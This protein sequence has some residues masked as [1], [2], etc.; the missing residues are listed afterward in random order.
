MPAGST[1]AAQESQLAQIAATLPPLVKQLAQL[2]DL[3]AV[4]AGR[5]P[6]QAPTENFD[7]SK[8]Q[9]PEDLP[10]S[11]PSALVEQRPDVL[12]AEANLHA[13]SA[14]IGIAIANRLPNIELTAK[15]RQHGAGAESAVH[16]GHGLLGRRRGGH[17]ADLPGRHAAASGARRQ[18]R[19]RAG[20][21]T[22]S[23]HR[24]DGLSECGRYLVRARTGRRGPEGGRERRGR[25]QNHAGSRAASMAGRLRRTILRC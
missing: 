8:L 14:K 6:S 19:L 1:V 15:C 16:R 24:S 17:G 13:A 18:G 3:L 2:R 7:L 10:V 11:L 9:L 23:Q 12:Q 25:R 21:R 4:L 5:F 20:R 22:I